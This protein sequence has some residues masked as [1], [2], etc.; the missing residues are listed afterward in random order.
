[1]TMSADYCDT[2]GSGG[3][4]VGCDAFGGDVG[5]GPTDDTLGCHQ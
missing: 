4:G 3:R 1:M 5:L 2:L